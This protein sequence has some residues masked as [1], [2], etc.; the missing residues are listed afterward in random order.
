MRFQLGFGVLLVLILGLAYINQT[1]SY[2]F[3]AEEGSVVVSGK[4]NLAAVQE[5]PTSSSNKNNNNLPDLS[6][7]TN[8]Q[9][10]TQD[11][12]SSQ[13]PSGEVVGASS[14]QQKRNLGMPATSARELG[15]MPESVAPESP[16]KEQPAETAQ[17][18]LSEPVNEPPG[19]V[20]A[21]VSDMIATVSPTTEP[22]PPSQA[23]GLMSA[24]TNNNN[25]QA[26]SQAPSS[27]GQQ[28]LVRQEDLPTII[29]NNKQ[30]TQNKQPTQENKDNTN[31]QQQP[32]SPSSTD[33]SSATSPQQ[34]QT[35]AV[36]L[37]NSS[38]PMS[39]ARTFDSW[40]N[41]VGAQSSK[42]GTCKNDVECNK[43]KGF[44]DGSCMGGFGVCCIVA[45]SCG[46]KSIEN[47]TFF[48]NADY[49]EPSWE[50]RL[51]EVELKKKHKSILQ[52][53]IEFVEF[54][55]APPNHQ[56]ECITDVFQVK[57][58]SNRPSPY[59]L[60]RI[61][62]QNTG[63][64]M[65][66][67]VSQ[68][69]EPLV[70]SVATSGGGFPRR[71]SIRIVQMD[72]KNFLLAPP[73]CLQYYTDTIGHFRSFNLG[74]NLR[75]L[76]YAICFRIDNGYSGIRFTENFFGMNGPFCRKRI[77]GPG[78]GGFGRHNGSIVAH[79]HHLVIPPPGYATPLPKPPHQKFIQQ[80]EYNPYQFQQQQPQQPIIVGQYQQQ[81]QQQPQQIYQQQ[82][83]QVVQEQRYKR[84]AY[85]EP[86]ERQ[87][88]TLHEHDKEF[89]S[90][91]HDKHHEDYHH[92]PS[93]GYGPVPQ[94][95]PPPPP[96]P[97]SYGYE[98]PKYHHDLYSKE[99]KFDD[100][101]KSHEHGGHHPHETTES[102]GWFGWIGGSGKK[103]SKLEHGYGHN[104][105]SPHHQYG[106]QH[107]GNHQY[108]HHYQ[109]Q[110][111]GYGAAYGHHQPQQHG[112]YGYHHKEIDKFGKQYEHLE[113]KHE[114]NHLGKEHEKSSWWPSWGAS[115]KEEKK[116]EKFQQHHEA[117]F[118]MI[119]IP[120]MPHC[121]P[122]FCGQND[123]ITFPPSGDSIAEMCGNRFNRG[124]GPKIISGSPLVVYVSNRGHTRGSGFD[125]NYE[126]VF[127]IPKPY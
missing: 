120:E 70:L 43:S 75:N 5:A 15:A 111:G 63:Q 54:E 104:Q 1:N 74:K 93:G 106:E 117:L 44:A 10:S 30:I 55:L 71:W 108:G 18:Q 101:F 125:M 86:G 114:K 88:R 33:S 99:A 19:L 98:Q 68:I 61:C 50:A 6:S 35:S 52:I 31:D 11:Y 45:L 96:P 91:H 7:S 2:E 77:G 32:Q 73:G 22:L 124:R 4:E 64:H 9:A 58:A 48:A 8:E 100:K 85:S 126:Q 62:G 83:P 82:Q 24:L 59:S 102:K 116:L 38:L 76:Y 16:A 3:D 115:K 127:Y 103:E 17:G 28:T 42:Y 84:F 27:S 72:D 26:S 12:D 69:D 87:S 119:H 90:E 46:D 56:G 123:V 107:Y 110:H 13:K 97:P 23:R 41:C 34:Q 49:P 21:P 37:T 109:P 29:E 121:E 20:S 14:Q 39:S 65:Y 53:M 113:Y 67:D 94:Y 25:Q 60:L 80:Q 40:T 57:L 66:L 122:R 51:C 81:Q 36:G 92:Q 118:P 79:P 95:G 78:G 89:K 112:G 105:Y 47:N